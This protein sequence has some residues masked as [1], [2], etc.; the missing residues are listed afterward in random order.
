MKRFHEVTLAED[1]SFYT[2]N[3]IEILK[4]GKTIRFYE[5]D[6]KKDDEAEE[7]EKEKE[8]E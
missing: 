2:E 1:S 3:G 4:K 5:E 7:E 8:E 6:E